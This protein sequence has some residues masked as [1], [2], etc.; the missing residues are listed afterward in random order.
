MHMLR[1]GRSFIDRRLHRA[2]RKETR[3]FTN[4]LPV[5]LDR[6]M[7]VDMVARIV[8]IVLTRKMP[9]MVVGIV[10]IMMRAVPEMMMRSSRLGTGC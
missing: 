2:R 6:V 7:T 10:A 9:M 5:I 3:V 1:C 4:I 8:S